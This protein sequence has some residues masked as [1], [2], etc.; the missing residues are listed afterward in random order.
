MRVCVILHIHVEMD[1]GDVMSGIDPL[2]MAPSHHNDDVIHRF[3]DKG[4]GGIVAAI[5]ILGVLR[6]LMTP[7]LQEDLNMINEDGKKTYN[8]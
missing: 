3:T 7:T 4:G 8:E 1:G 2:N 5:E 6:H